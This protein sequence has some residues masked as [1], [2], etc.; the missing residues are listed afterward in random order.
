MLIRKGN[1]S[2][3]GARI[4]NQ[5]C[6]AFWEQLGHGC[7]SKIGDDNY[8]NQCEYCGA[9]CCG[10]HYDPMLKLCKPCIREKG[11]YRK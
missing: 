9:V 8:A 2:V 11:V 4:S 3:R 7:K 5:E 6:Q 1:P 10:M